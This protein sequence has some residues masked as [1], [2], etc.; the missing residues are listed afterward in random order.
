MSDSVRP[1]RWQPTRLPH[2]W[3]SPGKNTGVGC[4]FLLQ[5][6]QVKS[7]SEVAQSCPTPSD[8]MDCRPPGSS[9]H[10]IFQATVLEWGAIAFSTCLSIV[11]HKKSVCKVI[12]FSEIFIRKVFSP[13]IAHYFRHVYN[14]PIHCTPK[15]CSLNLLRVIS[16]K[17]NI[18]THI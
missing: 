12:S 15:I 13:R 10:G 5:C 11:Q 3:D 4:H 2:P 1:H 17:N 16:K 7:E 9:V 18:V 6:M 14:L 8:P